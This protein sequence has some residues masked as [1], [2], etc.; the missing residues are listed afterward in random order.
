MKNKSNV[1]L[2]C[3]PKIT[4]VGEEKVFNGFFF[5]YH[6]CEKVDYVALKATSG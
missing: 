2:I 1:L 5:I 3:F 6:A 4:E